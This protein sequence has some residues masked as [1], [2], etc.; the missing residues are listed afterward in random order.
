[1]ERE[2]I[3]KEVAEEYGSSRGIKKEAWEKR[4]RL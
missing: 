3:E 1:L 4:G 2:E